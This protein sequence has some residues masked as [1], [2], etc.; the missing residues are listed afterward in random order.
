MRILGRTGRRDF[1]N[2][3]A[4]S[5]FE[6]EQEANR[7]DNTVEDAHES[8][9]ECQ[10]MDFNEKTRQDANSILGKLDKIIDKC[11]ME[12]GNITRRFSLTPLA[13]MDQEAALLA[14]KTLSELH[15]G[16][17]KNQTKR[18]K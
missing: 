10:Q 9:K 18:V 8:A 14:V 4:K 3:M 17:G 5:Y 7:V 6:T 11:G 2:M 16:I 15:R 1:A 12:F 13:G